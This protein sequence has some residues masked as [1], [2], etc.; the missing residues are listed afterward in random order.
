MIQITFYLFQTMVIIPI[1][2]TLSFKRCRWR[3]LDPWLEF[4][5]VVAFVLLLLKI[6]SS[7]CGQFCNFKCHVPMF[8]PNENQIKSFCYPLKW[9]MLTWLSCNPQLFLISCLFKY[10]FDFLFYMTAPSQAVEPHAGTS[11]ATPV[12][13]ATP[14]KSGRIS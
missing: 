4:T 11:Q 5:L 14:T 6:V 13:Q 7:I 3:L 10:P 1:A 9:L 12:K 2:P 8:T